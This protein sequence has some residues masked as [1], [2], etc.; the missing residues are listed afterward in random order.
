MSDEV[1]AT[2]AQGKRQMDGDK[3]A[4]VQLIHKHVGIRQRINVDLTGVEEAADAILDHIQSPAERDLAGPN[5]TA[6]HATDV[7]HAAAEEIERLSAEVAEWKQAAATEASL[8][9]HE[10]ASV[11]QLKARIALLEG[12]APPPASLYGEHTPITVDSCTEVESTLH[13]W[14]S[15]YMETVPALGKISKAVTQ[16][17]LRHQAL[18][19]LS[20]GAARKIANALNHARN[21]FEV[22]ISRLIDNEEPGSELT[23][24]HIGEQMMVIALEAL[25]EDQVLPPP[26]YDVLIR[27]CLAEASYL[28]RLHSHHSLWRGIIEPGWD[29]RIGTFGVLLARRISDEVARIDRASIT[30]RAHLVAEAD[31][32]QRG[33]VSLPSPGDRLVDRSVIT[34]PAAIA[35]RLGKTIVNNWTGGAT[36]QAWP[37]GDAVVVYARDAAGNAVQLSLQDWEAK[38]LAWGVSTFPQQLHEQARAANQALFQLSYPDA[39]ADELRQIADEID[40]GGGCDGCGPTKLDRGEFCS[41][42]AATNLRDLAAALDLKASIAQST[43]PAPPTDA[44]ITKIVGGLG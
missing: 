8:R 25:Q 37:D 14:L 6:A 35:V 3:D 43:P 10:V 33:F 31:A 12:A 4:L 27:S 34:A 20:T 5:L 36:L 28:A 1:K 18:S 23:E 32:R 17:V 16:S 29:E 30:K 13:K 41:F 21:H 26:D 2:P 9:R 19:Q 15:D 7:A 42:V 38:R 39:R 22:V 44:A 24:A 40:C 11:E